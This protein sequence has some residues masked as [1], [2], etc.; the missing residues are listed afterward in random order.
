MMV[1]HV[2]VIEITGA[3]ARKRSDCE[4][5]TAPG[6]SADHA[7][8]GRAYADAFSRIHMLVMPRLLFR[9]AVV[10]CESRLHGAQHESR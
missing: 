5:R 7:S 4:A 9:S 6:K 3:A 2:P 8:A 1:V 10:G